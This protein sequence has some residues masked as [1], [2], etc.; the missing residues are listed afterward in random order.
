[1]KRLILKGML[2]LILIVSFS[3][4]DS[5]T[6][7][8]GDKGVA[9]TESIR[10]TVYGKVIGFKGLYDSHAWLGI[11]FA[12]PPVGDLR[13]RSPQKPDSWQGMKESL[14]FKSHCPQTANRNG[15]ISHLETGTPTGNEDCLYLNIWTPQFKVGKVPESKERLPV[16][17]WIHGGGNEIGTGSLYNGGNLATTHGLVVV[18][19]NYRLGPFGWFFHKSIREETENP[20]DQS[21]NYGTLDLMEALRWVGE[22]IE[23][24][25]GDPG[26]IT[27]FGQSAGGYNIYSLLVSPYSKGLF[28]KAVIQSGGN[29]FSSVEEAEEYRPGDKVSRKVSSSEALVRLLIASDKAEDA[30]SAVTTLGKMSSL[31]IRTFLRSRN[32]DDILNAFKGYGKNGSLQTRVRVYSNLLDGGV[33]PAEDPLNRLSNLDTYNSVPIILGTNRDEQKLYMVFDPDYVKRTLGVIYSI[34]DKKVYRRDVGFMS[35]AWKLRGVD[36][37]AFALKKSSI[38]PVFAFRFDWDEEPNF[39]ITN[40]GEVLGAA[41][42]FE[43]PF[44]FGHFDLN[45]RLANL[46]ISA[47]DEGRF[48]L[49]AAMMSYWAEFAYNG[50]P[51]RGRKGDLPLWKNWNSEPDKEKIL[52]FDTQ[53]D[54]GIRMSKDFVTFDKLVSRIEKDNTLASPEEK[55]RM[56]VRMFHNRF[57]WNQ[58][59]YNN[60][61]KSGC[62]QFNPDDLHK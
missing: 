9:D 23:A 49:S 11:P 59:T 53:E 34:N 2:I 14:E 7:E 8:S 60:L 44:V 19:L 5:A 35:D 28:Q 45:S 4:C 43:I 22:N 32:R 48:T 57:E 29:S 3:G 56:F 51:G 36:R 58:D 37:A 55:C 52:V 39:I 42:G 38:N 61:G 21:G 12:K 47:N 18:S 50:D 26:N 24:F 31:E 25:G 33:I 10:T 13:W 20:T 17:V 6:P 46:M 40:F 30:A 41:H 1:M 54:G 27:V 16:M 15:G 62:R